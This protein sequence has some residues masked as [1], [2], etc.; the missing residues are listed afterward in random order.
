MRVRPPRRTR[1]H[2][3]TK[4][5]ERT[6]TD[7]SSGRVELP[8]RPG[9]LAWH[10]G[11]D[12]LGGRIG[13]VA[14]AFRGYD[15]TNQGRSHELLAHPAYGPIV[16]EALDE[17]SALCSRATGR[18][19]DLAA[20]VRDRAPSTLDTYAAD[21]ALI[22][23]IELAQLRI[24]ERVF[25]VAVERSCLAFGYSIGEV[26]A[27]IAAGV[28]RM[29]QL[30]PVLLGMAGD[31]AELVD[32]TSMGILF[33]RGPALPIAEVEG[34]CRRISSEGAGLIGPSAYLSPNAA[35]LIGQGDTLERFG[36]GD[37]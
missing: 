23:A 17:G 15:V 27:L 20:R 4:A 29:D 1:H 19:V 7:S 32:G 5:G 30:L 26:S 11:G 10:G 9:L 6:P 22:V 18:P 33:S 3:P 21:A 8:G 2:R 13:T 31:A 16:R 36:R 34:L 12:E 37:G 28:Y 25:G 14:L 35:L 24:L